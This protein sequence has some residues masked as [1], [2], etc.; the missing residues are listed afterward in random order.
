MDLV[1]TFPYSQRRSTALASRSSRKNN[2]PL[3]NDGSSLA[4]ATPAL[5]HL[6][7]ERRRAGQ[8]DQRGWQI[9][10]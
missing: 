9:L 8:I 7:Y 5:L 10:L 3:M 2:L 1:N 6:E 4:V